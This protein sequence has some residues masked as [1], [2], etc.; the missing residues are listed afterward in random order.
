M[1]YLNYTTAPLGLNDPVSWKL[2]H[3]KDSQIPA[4]SPSCAAER[5]GVRWTF[6]AILAA[7]AR[8]SSIGITVRKV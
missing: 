2:S 5:S 3:F 1:H 6:P 4:R 7:A 8:I